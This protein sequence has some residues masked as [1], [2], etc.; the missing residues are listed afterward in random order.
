MQPEPS[1]E[2]A[3]QPVPDSSPNPQ[4]LPASLSSLP[5][6]RPRTRRRNGKV[7]QLPRHLREQI[8]RLLED[9]ATYPAII[10]SLGPD[11]AHL[12]VDNLSQWKNGG[13]QDWLQ[14]Q[15]YLYFLN[16]GFEAATEI[17][18]ETS[19][20]E[21]IH[22]LLRISAYRII[23][24]LV[25]IKEDPDT[26]EFDKSWLRL[27]GMVPRLTRLVM[28]LRN[29]PGQEPSLLASSPPSNTLAVPVDHPRDPS[30]ICSL[31][32][33]SPP[34]AQPKIASTPKSSAAKPHAG[35]AATSPGPGTGPTSVALQT[36]GQPSDTL[37][38]D[39]LR[40]FTAPLSATPAPRFLSAPLSPL[41][42]PKSKKS[43]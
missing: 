3:S 41:V 43:D 35:S 9:G 10:E 39:A 42:R 23:H 16:Y 36:P 33:Q 30:N 27:V 34:A 7:A 20:Q 25:M 31:N 19:T 32:P 11:G 4:T 2:P 12:T 15:D 17:G 29:S 40:K 6:L 37:V 21:V 1:L 26:G 5:P 8:N 28:E 18:R 14:E 38:L 24:H 22:K 13:Y